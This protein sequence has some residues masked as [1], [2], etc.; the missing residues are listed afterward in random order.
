MLEVSATIEL[1]EVSAATVEL[2]EV[3][4]ATIELREVS[5]ATIEHREASATIELREAEAWND[6]RQMRRC[7]FD[8]DEE[9]L[10]F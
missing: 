6:E 7:A 1:G 3:S 8:G 9:G 10:V 4:A 5:A 2:R